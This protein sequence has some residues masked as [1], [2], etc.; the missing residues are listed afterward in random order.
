M[1]K[2]DKSAKI[3]PLPKPK[4]HKEPSERYRKFA[5]EPR[6][7]RMDR[8]RRAEIDAIINLCRGMTRRETE[9]NLAE[10]IYRLGKAIRNIRYV[11]N[12]AVDGVGVG[13]FPHGPHETENKAAERDRDRKEGWV[14]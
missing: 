4:K 3:I 1:N 11:A 9:V 13:V 14:W 12:Q 10:E 2:S 5:D 6:I 7:S 8:E